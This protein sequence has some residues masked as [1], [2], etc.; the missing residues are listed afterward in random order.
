VRRAGRQRTK[1]RVKNKPTEEDEGEMPVYIRKT[2]FFY[3]LKDF[4]K[5]RPTE[6]QVSEKNRPT[7]N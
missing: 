7:K 4:E 6:D 1:K 2:E 3:T 5:S